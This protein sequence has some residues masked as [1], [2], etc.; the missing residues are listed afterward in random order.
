M[1]I[2]EEVYNVP[3][4]KQDEANLLAAESRWIMN[5]IKK[6]Y[7]LVNIEISEH[8]SQRIGR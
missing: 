6:K 7:P 4:H 8:T 3:D 1:S 2:V 5:G